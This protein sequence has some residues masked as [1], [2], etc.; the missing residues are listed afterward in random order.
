MMNA[1]ETLPVFAVGVVNRAA[2]AAAAAAAAADQTSKALLCYK[3]TM[4][5]YIQQYV[6]RLRRYA[7]DKDRTFRENV[8]ACESVKV[9]SYDM[10]VHAYW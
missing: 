7:N 6:F 8:G 1:L 4:L 2:S 5:S 10:Y 3:T 9:C